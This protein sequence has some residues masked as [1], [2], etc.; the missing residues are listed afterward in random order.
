LSDPSSDRRALLQEALRAIEELQAKLDVSE[1]SRHEPIAIVGVGCR[2][3]GADTPEAYWG[4]LRDG[5]DAVSQVPAERW[6]IERWFDPDPSAPGKTYT[7]W[8][9]FLRDCDKFDS[10]FFG[11]APREAVRMDPQHR[12]LL[13]VAWQALENAGQSPERLRGSQ[14]GVYV[15]ITTSEYMQL[16][17]QR[18]AA[19]E[20]DAYLAPGNTS[21]ACAGRVSYLLG[22]HGPSMAVDT[23]CS[24]SLVAVHLA[25]QSLRTGDCDLALAGGVNLILVPETFVCFSKWGM[26]AKDGRCKTF[27]AAADGFVRGEG[28]GVVVL[29]RLRDALAE[30]DDVMAVIRG[31]A[32][33]QD[34]PSSGLSVPNGRA[35]EAVIRRA[36]ADAGLD[37]GDVS[38]VEAH[39]TGTSLGDPIEVEALGA[40]YGAGHSHDRPLLIGSVKTNLGHLEASAGV[41]GLIKVVLSLQQ[42]EIPPHLHFKQGNPH[43][44]WG[45]LPVSVPTQR[46]PWPDTPT[47][48]LAGVSA[49]GFS[50]TNVHLIVEGAPPRQVVERP[51]APER[52]LHVLCLSGKGAPALIESAQRMEAFLAARTDASLANVAYSAN[53]GRSHF[54][55]RLAVV[56][57]SAEDARTALAAFAAGRPAAGVA[58]GQLPAGRP[59]LAFLFT[60]QGAQYA[61]MGRQLYETQ[62]SFRAALER[63]DQLLRPHLERPLL[64]VIFAPDESVSLLDETA[65]TQPALFA[66]EY[67]LCELWRSWGVEPAAVL[68]HSVGEYAAACVAGVFSL[69]DGLSLIAERARLMQALPRDGGMAALQASEQKVTAALRPYLATLSMAAV[70]GPD[71]VVVSGR[72]EALDRVIEE[73]GRDGIKASRLSVSHAFHSPLMEPMLAAFEQAASLVNL[74]PPR[75]P[76]VSNLTG[77]FAGAEVAQAAYWRRHVREPVRFASGVAALHAKGYRVFVEVGPSP[78]LLGMAARCLPEGAGVLLPSLRKGKGDWRPLLETLAA[79]H[80]QGVEVDW[81]A[82][83]RGHLRSRVVLPGYPFQRE[84]YWIKAAAQGTPPAIDAGDAGHPLLGHRVRSPL[85]K[86]VVFE[87]RTTPDAPA[88]LTDHKVHGRVVF[89][90]TGYLEMASAAA[91]LVIGPHRLEDVAVLEP[92]VLEAD[93]ARNVQ[94][95]LSSAEAGARFKIFSAAAAADAWQLHA[96]GR[97]VAGAAAGADPPSLQEARARC[98]EQVEVESLHEGLRA[99]GLDFGPRFRGIRRLWRAD[100]EAVGEVAFPDGLAAELEGYRVHPALLDSCLQVLVGAWPSKLAEST[101]TYLPLGIESFTLGAKADGPLWVH[102]S[103][104][105]NRGAGDEAVTG[106]LRLYDQHGAPLGEVCG[107]AVKRA[108]R[109]VVERGERERV[110]GWLYEVEWRPQPL[111]SDAVGSPLLLAKRADARVDAL[112]AQHAMSGYRQLLPDLE[113]L[114][115][116]YVCQAFLRLGFAPRRAERMV[117]AELAESLGVATG[118]RRLF[119][120]LLEMLGEAGVLRAAGEA[121]EF[122]RPLAAADPSASLA[123]I[124]SRHPASEVQ[125]RLVER[126]GEALAE[127]LRGKSDPLQLLFPGGSLQA[128]ER[129]YQDSPFAGLYNGLIQEALAGVV[130]RLPPD[131]KLRVLEIGAGTGGTTHS[132]LP[133]LPPDRTEY[134]F[135]DV[136]PIFTAKAAEK[137][138]E[139]AFVSYEVLDIERDTDS[140]GFAGRRF[141]VV[142][143]AN[144][145]HATRDLRQTLAHVKSLLRPQG[146][147]LLLEGTKRQRWVDLTFGLTDG[148]WRFADTDLRPSY[149]VLSEEGWLRL[150]ADQGFD[151]VA[152]PSNGRG[153]VDGQALLV[154]RAAPA[155][156]PGAETA[157]AEGEWLV[158]ADRGGLAEAL[159]AGLRSRGTRVVLIAAGEAYQETD[160]GF[161]LDSRSPGDVERLFSEGLARRPTC[162]VV[163]L[164]G[165]DAALGPD[166]PGAE[167]ERIQEAN[168]GSALRVAQ[169]MARRGTSGLWLVTRGAQPVRGSVTA[170]AQATLWGLGKVV[171]LEHPEV[172]CVRIDL[173]PDAG[174]QEADALLAELCDESGEDQVGFR[175]GCRFAARLVPSRSARA[176]SQAPGT[177][178]VRLEAT[179]PGV[180]SGLAWRPAGRRAPE[181]GEVEIRVHASGLNFRD[182]L[183]AL[184]MYP[185]DAGPLGGECAGHVVAVGPGVDRF[186]VGDAVLGIAAGSHSTYVTT[187]AELVVPKPQQLGFAEATTIPSAFMTAHHTL[188]GLARIQAGERVLI[189][190]AAGGV[191]MAAVQLAQR[192]G[193][194]VFATAGS[195]EKRQAL[196]RLGVGRVMDSR[197]LAFAD[198]LMASTGGEG[199]DVVLNSLSG[200]FIPRSLSVLRS[201]GRFLEIGKRGIWDA[202]RVAA[203]KPGVAY[204]VV[205]LAATSRQDPALIG[206]VLGDVMAGIE[207]GSLRPLPYQVFP[208]DEAEAAFRLMAQARHVGKVVVDLGDSEATTLPAS[209]RSD[210]TYLITG[211]VAGLGLLI[212]EWMV[213]R[214]ARSLVLAAR[215][216][217]KAASA[218]TIAKLERAGARVR[219][220]EADV[221]RDTDVDAILSGIGQSLPPL[222]GVIHSAGVLDDGA[223]LQQEWSRFAPVLAPKVQGSWAL[224]RLTRDLQLDHFILFSSASALIGSRG[225]SNHAAANAFLDAFAHF[226]RTQGLPGLSI[227]WGAWSDVGAAAARKVGEN[228]K[229]RGIGLISPS[230]GLIA[231]ELSLLGGAAQVGVAPIDWERFLGDPQN[232]RQPFYAELRRPAETSSSSAAAL[233]ARGAPDVRGR[234]EKAP[235]G[236]RRALL[237]DFVRENAVEVLGLDA[238]RGIDEGQPL[239]ELGL[240]S[241]MAVELRNRLGA[242]L[243]LKRALS[244]TLLFDY[245]TLAAVAD[246]LGRDVLGWTEDESAAP[247]SEDRAKAEV[248]RL[249]DAEAQALLVEELAA[250]KKGQG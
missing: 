7:R 206:S 226:R 195:E 166:A 22:L 94:L 117:P 38:Y 156:A 75:L 171:A 32:V 164:W 186:R 222:R 76:L 49:F 81:P 215:S 60:G 203:F 173:D 119:G 41:A 23:A 118:H 108:S 151:A 159:A 70:N 33:N 54:S 26:M 167:L 157:R 115:L 129:L 218:A 147:L 97:L 142:L 231:L 207:R 16:H 45:R 114:C 237:V 86:D 227:N 202:E 149:P 61:G 78:T 74:R 133:R 172:R 59:R 240:D 36:L 211:G 189:H 241:L 24:S 72:R 104:R 102:A 197:S 229:A 14:T 25:C 212:A 99:R 220:L 126:C 39:G 40:V 145:I 10:H 216:A 232:A 68:G 44:P 201:G 98:T 223:L 239:R 110:A 225:Q 51:G 123:A 112:S 124:L 150:L 230:R 101:E 248:D 19:T 162:G 64:S 67:A 140:Q 208:R 243:G 193:A 106:D 42:R 28:S 83:D 176:P 121:W 35:Q 95:V 53:V 34:G 103:L 217:P 214:G 132:L 116:E 120:R 77:D 198:E 184:G 48:H 196:R 154:A 125:I 69:E 191:G 209:F 100:A 178:P 247:R 1:R 107:F 135:S 235:P 50:G 113:G 213:E 185:G 55:H 200:E 134:V 192:A 111:P 15:G 224:H 87:T 92:L 29:K 141:D 205:D 12:L 245:P 27:D 43:I 71:N 163:Y 6:D 221:S 11:V 85:I 143:A 187:R 18:L 160:T 58:T 96:E 179:T 161:V 188:V 21:N 190:A 63:C 17:T 131:R 5:V 56:A 2:F 62:P 233:P 66:L 79:L 174:A 30:G 130:D 13:E 148:W 246:Y 183:N 169:A 194:E 84:S 136:S 177:G 90:A 138:R 31:T 250:L 88:F 4:M 122:S 199:V 153:E 180:L 89:P 155:P 3:P 244:A 219:V 8:G 82:F 242:G 73:L 168:C 52:P 158:F 57:D 47:R 65:Y 37:P 144:V 46:T 234:L 105:P 152:I 170:P 238:S 175:A 181:A 165:L 137:F 249:E 109:G 91:E 182:V 9:G 20:L 128:L 80:V 228:V 204:F 236:R 210:G 93:E 127:V 146:L 139:H